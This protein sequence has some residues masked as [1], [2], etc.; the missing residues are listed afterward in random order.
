M[1]YTTLGYSCQGLRDKKR[2]ERQINK[3]RVDA[4]MSKGGGLPFIYASFYLQVMNC[5]SIRVWRTT[6][7]SRALSNETCHCDKARAYTQS[8]AKI[9]EP[10]RRLFAFLSELAST[11]VSLSVYDICNCFAILRKSRI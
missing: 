5:F 6:I 3:I 1:F 9:H 8:I 2:L 10:K 4:L 11:K 7:E